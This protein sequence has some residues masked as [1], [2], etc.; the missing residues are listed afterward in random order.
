MANIPLF[1]QLD[2]KARKDPLGPGYFNALA[3]NQTA[4]DDF[5]VAEHLDSGEH[6]AAEIARTMGR[7]RYNAGAYSLEGFNGYA[8]GTTNPAV[9]DVQLVLNAGAFVSTSMAVDC[10][11]MSET[12]SSKPCMTTVN[13]VDDTHVE[14]FSK[15][16]STALG[17]AGNTWTD[18]DC[19]LSVGVHSLPLVGDAYTAVSIPALLSREAWL[20]KTNYNNLVTADSQLRARYLTTHTA[21]GAHNVR[22]VAKASGYIYYSGGT[23]VAAADAVNF[24]TVT[25][26]GTGD[27]TV[28]YGSTLTSPVQVFVQV[29]YPRTAGLSTGFAIY[30]LGCPRS[31]CTTTDVRLYFYG[32][33]TSTNTWSRADCD[34]LLSVH[35]A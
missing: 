5:H 10:T 1:T 12:G 2:D 33:S 29:S 16:L 22:E 8:S 20:T 4:L 21:A 7:I 24:G 32:Y 27:V 35:G 18:E 28:A 31:T 34:F 3:M 11:N 17:V 6:N 13:V 23:Y 9:G 15:Y 19:N 14:F 30:G 25:K 26:N